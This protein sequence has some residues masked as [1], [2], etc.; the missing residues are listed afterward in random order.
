MKELGAMIRNLLEALTVI[1][2]HFSLSAIKFITNTKLVRLVSIFQSWETNV[3]GICTPVSVFPSLIEVFGRL[4]ITQMHQYFDSLSLFT[5][6]RFI[7]RKMQT[8]H[9]RCLDETVCWTFT[10][11]SVVAIQSFDFFFQKF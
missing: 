6:Y 2:F 1:K 9:V 7:F 11:V 10:V 8:F 4:L 3:I 5:Y